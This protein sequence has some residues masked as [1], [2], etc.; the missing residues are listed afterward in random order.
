MKTTLCL[1]CAGLIALSAPSA[2]KTPDQC[3]TIDDAISANEEFVEAILEGNL[4]A[5]LHTR[6]DMTFL[7]V[8][9]GKSLAP[10]HATASA[11]AITAL[12]AAL[13]VGNERDAMLA[14]M[15]NYA[16]L[17]ENFK[18]RL[19]TS[20][21]VAMLD[22]AGFS[23]Q[24]ILADGNPDW[25]KVIAVQASLAA[26][27]KALDGQL[28]KGPLADLLHDTVS[29]IDAAIAHSDVKWLNASA[30]ILLDSVDLVEAVVKNKSSDACP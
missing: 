9:L 11:D 2:A 5:R 25:A 4:K 17:V 30:L 12:D 24:A 21:N 10:N 15:Q 7:N 13:A 28:A 29:S 26:D 23:L 8:E 14:A 1:A 16:T 3:K 18:A 27:V 20:Q 19:P 22:H 6:K